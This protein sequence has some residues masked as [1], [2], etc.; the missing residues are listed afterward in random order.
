MQF[1][2]PDFIGENI[3]IRLGGA[4]SQYQKMD[5]NPY[6]GY[7]T[8]YNPNPNFGSTYNYYDDHDYG[9]ASR[10]VSEIAKQRM[11]TQNGLNFDNVGRPYPGP[12]PPTDFEYFT[13]R[14][15]QQGF[16]S[17]SQGSTN[18]ANYALLISTNIHYFVL[19]IL[20]VIG[21]LISVIN[22]VMLVVIYKK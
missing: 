13:Q 14:D 17:S 9:Y 20:I 22:M 4:H 19:L 6:K 21:V 3:D 8:D 2:S 5:N 16:T 15:P 12:Q 1:E 18:T 11:S 7:Q 10:P